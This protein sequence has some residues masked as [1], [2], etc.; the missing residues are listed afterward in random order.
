MGVNMDIC[1]VMEVSVSV[2][3]QAIEAIQNHL[4]KD[5]DALCIGLEVV[6]ASLQDWHNDIVGKFAPWIANDMKVESSE[7]LQ[8]IV[9]CAED[10]TRRS[11]AEKS[12]KFLEYVITERY[13]SGELKK[14]LKEKGRLD[15]CKI[16]DIKKFLN[17]FMDLTLVTKQQWM[18]AALNRQ[19]FDRNSVIDWLHIL[20]EHRRVINESVSSVKFAIQ[21]QPI[22]KEQLQKYFPL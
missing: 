7:E 11:V 5:K 4:K 13:G 18:N 17:D 22:S 14:Q 10:G 20:N 12:L 9:R 8:F 19:P 15:I 6:N 3:G 21:C 2:V 16:C 1:K